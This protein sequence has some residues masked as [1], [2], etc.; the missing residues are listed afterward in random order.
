MSGRRKDGW[1][2]REDEKFRERGGMW[3]D[4]VGGKGR[5]ER[6]RCSGCSEE[7]EE[8]EMKWSDTERGKEGRKGGRKEDTF[9]G[10][11]SPHLVPIATQ[12]SMKYWLVPPSHSLT[13]SVSVSPSLPLSFSPSISNYIYTHIHTHRERKLALSTYAVIQAL[14]HCQ[15][16]QNVPNLPSMYRTKRIKLCFCTHTSYILAIHVLY[17]CTSS[18]YVH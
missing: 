7:E 9:L 11:G 4:V 16:H 6:C 1:Q 5:G 13:L 3:W 15:T 8:R 2:R 18:P 17:Y 12:P 10:I 14:Q